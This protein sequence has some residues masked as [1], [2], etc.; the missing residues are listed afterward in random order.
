MSHDDS[1]PT[2]ADDDAPFD[3]RVSFA[4]DP[5]GAPGAADDP[6]NTPTETEFVGLVLPPNERPADDGLAEEPLDDG[7]YAPVRVDRRV[8]LAGLLIAGASVLLLLVLFS[9][10]DDAGPGA[11]VPRPTTAAP[12]FIERQTDDGLG[13]PEAQPPVYGDALVG[14]D[15]AMVDPYADPY[16][17]SPSTD[18]GATRP[19]PAPVS[20]SGGAGRNPALS[21][22]SGRDVDPQEASFER[23]IGS[24]LLVG[25][26]AP[27]RPQGDGRPELPEGLSPEAE[28]EI[29]EL[30]A[31][32][33][34]LAPPSMSTGAP[35]TGSP[36]P[37]AASGPVT[38]GIPAPQQPTNAS[39]RPG[40]GS[41]EAFRERTSALGSTAYAVRA[42]RPQH[43]LVLSAGTVVPA[44]L[45]TG[46]SSELPG[47]VVAQVT[48]NVYDSR[49]QRDVLI[50]AGSRLVGEY[51][52]QVAYGQNRAL[53]AWTRLLFPDG[54]SVSLPGLPTQD[55]RGQAGLRDRVDRHTGRL[56][57]S[58][59]MLAAVGAGVELAAPS[60]GGAFGSESPQETVARQI[61][62]ELS[63]VATEV[64]RRDLDVQPTVTIRPGFRF[65]VF[66]A[67]DLAFAAPYR[68]RA[69]VGRF[70]RAASR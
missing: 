49:N 23:A 9:G 42:E 38:V 26:G 19:T 52:D 33:A 41:R 39:G 64:V 62:I 65:Y 55:L 18:Y 16:A 50:P 61:A 24:P 28:Q 31:I 25:T 56:F 4:V 14:G 58:A 68:D 37:Y 34:A 66:L 54:R 12:E 46:I 7:R 30:Q 22:R 1:L 53:V 57:G 15:Y 20:A 17:G 59:V 32:A 69:D 36:T 27:V 11:D 60:D 51:D 29:Y 21:R 6:L 48:R 44:A 70:S 67:R 3:D 8:V 43:D 10:S 45:V 40:A 5:P 47:A 63:R 13:S 35:P 2:G